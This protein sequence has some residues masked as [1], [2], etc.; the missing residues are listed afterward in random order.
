MLINIAPLKKYRDFRLLFFGQMISFLGSMVSYVAIPYQVY[1]LTKD[2]F[3]VGLLGLVQL[4]PV[5]IFGILGG[6]YA[7][8][9]NRRKLLLVS[10]FLLS[11]LI[12][13]LTLN[14]WKD[15]P[16]VPLIFI[17]VAIFQGVLGFHRPAMDALTQKLVDK[18]DYAAVGAL[19]SFRYA[20]G[21]IVGP[22]L[23]GVL[24]ASFGI[25]GAFLFDL[26]TFV[27]AYIAL[28]LM[29]SMPD[30]DKKEHSPWIDAKEGLRY[31]ISKPELVGTYVVDIVA[32]VFAFPVALFPSMAENWGG[33]SAA[34][35]LFSAMAV[36][37]LV[38]T[39]FSGWTAKVFHHGRAVVIAAALWAVFIIGVGY[40]SHLWVALAFLA[41]A[42]AADM[43]SGLFRGIIWNETVP[44]DL[45]GR[46]SGIEMI[47][48]MSG[49]LLGNARAGWMAS[50]VSVPFSISVGGTICAVA[51]IIT[52]FCLPQFWRYKSPNV[53]D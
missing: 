20:T 10:E 31:A 37:S 12:L 42:G 2:N 36:G 33:A 24:I 8:R 28:Y 25:K 26:V 21:A 4:L 13:G 40:A 16:S 3:L 49:P 35:L 48:Y 41:L 15:K 23:G 44:N 27:A 9:L 30:P 47:S 50:K 46:L 32:M 17:L 1:E 39:L 14:A 29:S 18:S 38:M 6:T 45:R 11:L 19:G 7:D 34:G 52:A 53:K 22:A 51:V 43:M 5:L